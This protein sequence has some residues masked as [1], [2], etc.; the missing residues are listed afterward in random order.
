M[1]A[2]RERSQS[3]GD[4]WGAC[5]SSRLWWWFNGYMPGS[6]ITQSYTLNICSLLYINYTFLSCKKKV[7]RFRAKNLIAADAVVL[8]Q[9]S[10][11]LSSLLLSP[12]QKLQK[13]N[14]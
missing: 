4:T 2:G 5:P 10:F 9:Y 8:T 12:L 7:I 13:L 3:H 1:G 6:E 11:Q 14:A